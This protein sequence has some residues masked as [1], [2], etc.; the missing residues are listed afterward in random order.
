MI[1]VYYICLTDCVLSGSA[2]AVNAR[3]DGPLVLSCEGVAP[4]SWTSYTSE[5]EEFTT[6][7]NNAGE[8]RS[9]LLYR[10]VTNSDSY[11]RCST[12]NGSCIEYSV[13]VF[14]K[15]NP[16]DSCLACQSAI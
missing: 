8:V 1:R 12:G 7:V 5:A 13:T 3:R 6:A 4:V 2:G 16:G 11:I 14:S 10:S 15:C 9:W